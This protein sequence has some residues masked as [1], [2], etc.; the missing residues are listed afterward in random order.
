LPL[1]RGDTI[2][3]RYIRKEGRFRTLQRSMRVVSELNST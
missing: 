2:S 3:E 1:G